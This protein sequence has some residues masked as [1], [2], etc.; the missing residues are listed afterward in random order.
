MY[1]VDIKQASAVRNLGFKL[2]GS[3]YNYSNCALEMI[4]NN[5]CDS[6]LES[7]W[8]KVK[9]MHLRDYY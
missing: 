9:E 1:Q 3:Q 5:C 4:W 2:K 8:R 6:Y 7:N